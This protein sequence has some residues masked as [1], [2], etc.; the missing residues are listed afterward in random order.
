MADG[1]TAKQKVRCHSGRPSDTLARDPALGLKG[2]FQ[3]AEVRVERPFRLGCRFDGR[4]IG[5]T[6]PVCLVRAFPPDVTLLSARSLQPL[7]E[8]CPG[9]VAR[10]EAEGMSKYLGRALWRRWSGYCSRI[11]R[12]LSRGQVAVRTGL[13]SNLLWPVVSCQSLAKVHH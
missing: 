13:R 8:G 10:Y 2:Q 11:G 4:F 9:M 6:L 3:G 1:A 12:T 7:V 5:I